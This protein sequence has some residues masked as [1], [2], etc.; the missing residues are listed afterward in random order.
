MQYTVSCQ[1]CSDK[2]GTPPYVDTPSSASFQQGT[3]EPSSKPFYPQQHTSHCPRCGKPRAS[4]PYDWADIL[5]T[6][7]FGL[8]RKNALLILQAY[9]ETKQSGEMDNLRAIYSY[10]T[11]YNLG[12]PAHPS[13]Q[14][15]AGVTVQVNERRQSAGKALL[16]FKQSHDVLDYLQ[17]AGFK[18]LL[19]RTYTA[20]IDCTCRQCGGQFTYIRGIVDVQQTPALHC[21]W[22]ASTDL[23]VDPEQTEDTAW[24]VLSINYKL[25]VHIIR[26]IYGQY[27]AQSTHSSFA[28][29]MASPDV[30]KVLTILSKTAQTKEPVNA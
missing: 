30:Q 13:S 26:T 2:H 29:Y 24:T 3:Q 5:C 23:I 4:R 7:Y 14:V 25:P 20:P 21:I 18:G 12:T 6:E 19:Q 16:M 9:N 15:H 10:T 1:T 8:T 27:Q 22:C 28:S 17:K 11:Q